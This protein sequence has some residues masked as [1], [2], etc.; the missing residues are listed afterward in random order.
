MV[1]HFM[2]LLNHLNLNKIFVVGHDWG[3]KPASR[4]ALYQPERTMGLVLLSAAYMPPGLFDLDQAIA[5]SAAYCG[6]DSL[7]Y[8]KFFDSDDAASIIENNLESFID[9]VYAI[10]TTLFKTDFAPT[11]KMRQWL[12]N[13]HRT[14]RASYMTE[15]DYNIV[16]QYLTKEMQPKLNWYRSTIAN[17]DWEDEKNIE[18]TIQRPIL[19]MRGKQVDICRETSFAKQSS[20]TPNIEIIDFDTGHWL[21]EEQPETIHQAIEEWIKKIS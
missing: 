5:N 9:L 10:N 21:M 18:P 2:I 17:V 16:R 7:G 20:F 15:N 19:F 11:G 4:I 3:M 1:D 8:W 12:T 14:A 6:Y 13:K